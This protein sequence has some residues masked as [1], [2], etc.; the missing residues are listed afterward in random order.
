MSNKPTVFV[1]D[2][3]QEVRESIRWLIESVDLAVETFGSGQEFLDAYDPDK[4]GC[5]VLDVRMPQSS[6]LELQ[7]KLLA[8][9]LEIPVIVVSAYGSVPVAV[10]AMKAGAVDFIEKP[11]S[12]QALLDRIHQAI[13]K[14]RDVRRRKAKRAE[15]AGRVEE[16]TSREREVMD[17][18]VVGKATKQI[19]IDLGIS[20]KTVEAHRAHIMQKMAA[21]SL[22]ELV[23][24]AVTV[25]ST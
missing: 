23:Q 9:G 21:D 22:A 17:L 20:P 5:I 4:P 6:G 24:M 3:D 2:D 15:V 14:D 10:E 18:V 13:A 8:R 1:V 16:L 7:K 25:R 19:A 11:F 12:D